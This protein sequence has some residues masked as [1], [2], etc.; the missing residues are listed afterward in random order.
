MVGVSPDVA[1]PL[2]FPDYLIH[3]DVQLPSVRLPGLGRVGGQKMPVKVPELGHAGVLLIRGSKGTT[4]YYEYGRY[5]P[6]GA[7]G[8]VRRQRIPD[9]VIGPDGH[10]TRES[11]TKVLAAVSR[12]A[13]QRGRIEAA[14]IVAPGKFPVML[15]Y[16]QRREMENNN[17]R[18]APYDL[19][20]NS[21]M[22]FAKW[23]VEAGGTMLPSGMIPSPAD[24]IEDVQDRFPDLRFKPAPPEAT[25]SIVAT[26]TGKVP[27][28]ATQKGWMQS[29][30]EGD[31]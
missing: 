15:Q 18:R 29:V 11:L 26:E 24:W 31:R 30:W 14:Y 13:G 22:H 4:K 16:A 3:V 1:I 17:P 2:A 10:A 12:L 7:L 19:T 23:T 5:P 27:R 9:V 8:R 6:S 20:K 21:C 28:W 25:I